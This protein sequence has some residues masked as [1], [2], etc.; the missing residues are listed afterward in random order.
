MIRNRSLLYCAVLLP[1]VLM[2]MC[3]L[4]PT[5]G[6]GTQTGNPV[7]MGK[8]L[9]AD[10]KP[11]A[12]ALV[13][14]VPVDYVPSFA[15]A[16][17]TPVPICT[18][19][20]GGNYRIYEIDSGAYNLEAVR[21]TLGVFKDSIKILPDSLNQYLGEAYLHRLGCISGTSFMPGQNDTNQVRVSI[22]MPGTGRITKPLIG[23]QFSFDFVPA[24]RYQII[25]DPTLNTYNVKVMDVDVAAGECKNLDTVQLAK[26]E[27]DTI[28]IPQT[29]VTGIWGPGKVYVV[30][31][32]ASVPAGQTLTI[33]PG[34]TLKICN[35]LINDGK[36]F[37]QG[38]KD[39]LVT[40]EY[41]YVSGRGGELQ[42]GA[43]SGP[44]DTSLFVNWAIIKNM[45]LGLGTWGGGT[46]LSN[47]AFVNCERA[48][49]AGDSMVRITNC[50]FRKNDYSLVHN[51][52]NALLSIFNGIF[53]D[54]AA[55]MSDQVIDPNVAFDHCLFYNNATMPI[56]TQKFTYSLYTDPLF[57]S[58][59]TLNPD[60][61]LQPGSPC[62]KA[63]IDSTDIGLY[64]TYKP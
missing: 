25:F 62:I 38:K 45:S 42:N 51:P 36:L 1:A 26:F 44:N 19:D 9:T 18:T 12:G 8:I 60:F 31:S 22:Y 47:C 35:Y 4:G 20:A 17:M 7:A 14:I 46:Y 64:S 55:I 6:N 61:H 16:N 37:I 32:M 58:L 63:G 53:I 39:S 49:E 59:D 54:N 10:G 5:A 30:L 15:L 13:R 2:T 57:V 11:A 56:D 50:I 33:L 40:I 48:F 52:A 28:E 23:G 21:D 34:T 3:T 41:G 24:G 43:V 29:S 27:P